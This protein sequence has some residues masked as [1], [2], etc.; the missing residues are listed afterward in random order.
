MIIDSP[1]AGENIHAYLKRKIYEKERN[2]TFE[3]DD[4]DDTKDYLIY[5]NKK[6]PNY[7]S[8]FTHNNY[9]NDNNNFTF[10]FRYFFF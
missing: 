3:D 10:N 1:I 6:N 5:N 2:E 4:L 9:N 7:N 8:Y